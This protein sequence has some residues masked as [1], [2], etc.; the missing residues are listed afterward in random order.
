MSRLF[1]W[2]KTHK[3]T[4]ALLLIVGYFVYSKFIGLVGFNTSSYRSQYFSEGPQTM[5]AEKG[6]ALRSTGISDIFPLPQE[7]PPAPDVKDRKVITE[8]YFSLLVNNVVQTQKQIIQKAQQLDGYMVN[9]N[10][11]NPQDAPSAT[12]IVRVPSNN[13]DQALD[14]YRSFAVKVISENL[15]G[16]DVTDQ[17]VDNQAKLDTLMQTKAK[18]EEIYNKARTIQEI[19]EV[20]N[21]IL[22]IQSQIDQIKGQQQ[23]LEQNAKMAKVTIYLS[24]DEFALPYAPSETW[25]PEVIFKQAVRS[26]IANVRKIA[27]LL[28]WLVVYSL[29]WIPLLVLL[30]ILKKKGFF[31]FLK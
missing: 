26:L 28:I 17:Y 13:L 20:Q 18:F 15:N 6:M 25:R 4:F 19:L 23:S 16:Q 9:S 3:L 1:S 27:T 31:N 22:N 8:S 30:Y 7:A 24:T 5:V 2:I 11:N 10:L 14:A 12:I 29:I 21:H